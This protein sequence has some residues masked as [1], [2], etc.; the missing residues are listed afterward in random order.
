MSNRC[1]MNRQCAS[2]TG[3]I[4]SRLPR[5]STAMSAQLPLASSQ[6]LLWLH[7]ELLSCN[8]RPHRVGQ[9]FLAE[10]GTVAGQRGVFAAFAFVENRFVILARELVTDRQL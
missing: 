9:R 1:V 8:D 5:R 6:S 3:V 2:L 7:A 4:E 10:R